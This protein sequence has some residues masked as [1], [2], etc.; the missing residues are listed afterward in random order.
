MKLVSTCLD[1]LA[2]RFAKY[3]SLRFHKAYWLIRKNIR[4]NPISKHLVLYR[5]L[6]PSEIKE[7]LHNEI[8]CYLRFFPYSRHEQ[9][10]YIYQKQFFDFII[11]KERV[12]LKNSGGDVV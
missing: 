10:E 6:P 11:R 1:E 2:L 9:I 4:L 8:L 5:Q 3:S 12:L 7:Y